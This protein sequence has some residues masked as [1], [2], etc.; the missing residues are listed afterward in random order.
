MQLRKRHRKATLN[1]QLRCWYCGDL[2]NA[3]NKSMDHKIPRSRG[4]TLLGVG[5]LVYACK[6]CNNE[7]DNM[8][9]EEYRKFLFN[10]KGKH[11]VF[12]GERQNGIL[13]PQVPTELRS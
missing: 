10:R 13:Q 11:I 6:S 8:T 9:I 7:K 3:K 12:F 2:L 4:G 5:N 1:S